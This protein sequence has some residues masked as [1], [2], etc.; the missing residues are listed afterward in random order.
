MGFEVTDGGKLK[1]WKYV[2]E[3]K[4]GP[5]LPVHTVFIMG[6]LLARDRNLLGLCVYI[7]IYIYALLIFLIIRYKF[8]FFFAM[9]NMR[10]VFIRSYIKHI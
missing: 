3:A 9:L 10:D 1:F 6:K 7:Y 8:N 2:E 4:F 5:G